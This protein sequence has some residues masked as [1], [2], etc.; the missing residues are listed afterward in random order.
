MATA[1]LDLRTGATLTVHT[2]VDEFSAP[3]VFTLDENG[4]DEGQFTEPVREGC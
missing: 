4:F 1:H 3:P 2:K